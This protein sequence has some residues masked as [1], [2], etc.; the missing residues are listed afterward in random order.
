VST[1]RSGFIVGALA[2]LGLTIVLAG[3][4]R[5]EA[6]HSRDEV[7]RAFAVQGFQLVDD[8]GVNAAI[9]NVRTI[10]ALLLPKSKEPFWVLRRAE[11]RRDG[12]VLPS[13]RP[14]GA[15]SRDLRLA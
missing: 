9:G 1:V 7:V 11:R 10:E 5:P 14:T 12:E 3:T 13:D 2:V 15:P 8:P 6:S 4:R